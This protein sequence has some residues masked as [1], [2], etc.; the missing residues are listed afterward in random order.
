MSGIE[1]PGELL[2]ALEKRDDFNEDDFV[3][4]HHSGSTITSVRLNPFK[5]SAEFCDNEKV[6]WCENAFYLK[7]RPSFILDPL[8]H[9]GCYYVQ[10]ASSM[11]LEYALRSCLDLNK[12]LNI[13]DLC[14][15][16]G[17]KSTLINSLLTADSLLVSNEVIRTRVPVLAEN[18]S[19]WGSANT[20]VTNNDPK[21]FIRTPGFFDVLVV[22]AP[23]SGSGLFRKQPEAVKEWSIAAVETCSL[24]QRRILSDALPAL[25]EGGLLVY[26]TCSYSPEENEEICDWLSNEFDL[27]SIRLEYQAE[28]GIRETTSEKQKAY[29]YRFYP[30]KVKGEGFF[31]ACF[32]KKN[33]EENP[34]YKKN[35]LLKPARSEYELIRPW[36]DGI[37]EKLLFKNGDDFYLMHSGHEEELNFL[38]SQLYIK[39]SGVSLGILKGKDF[40]PDH[41]FALSNSISKEINRVEVD[42]QQALSFLKKEEVKLSGEPQGFAL[43]TFR[44]FGL[45]WIKILQNRVN[46]YLPKEWRILKNLDD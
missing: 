39:K 4:I 43:L 42:L 27:E 12:R 25:K 13:L 29:G 35:N 8:F 9:A 38:S 24:R 33:E 32:R 1:I 20:V 22:D 17:G 7:E 37:N 11:F 44:G 23:C 15:A 14:A 10:E 6:S 45:G 46:N 31:I 34:R 36:V 21:D 2:S 30:D 16:P 41:Q 40:V 28:W 18:L 3:R 5:F 19:K 26:S